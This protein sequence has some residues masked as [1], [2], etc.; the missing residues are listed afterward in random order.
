MYCLFVC[1]VSMLREC[2]ADGSAGVATGG[3]VVAV[4]TECGEY[5]GGTPGSGVVQTTCYK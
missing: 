1:E 2:E 4:R 5:M 3:G